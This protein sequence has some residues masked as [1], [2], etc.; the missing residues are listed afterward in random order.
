LEREL[1]SSYYGRRDAQW[2][3]KSAI[4]S[5]RHLIYIETPGFCSTSALPPSKYAADLIAT[6]KTQLQDRPGLRAIICVPKVPDFAPGYEGMSAYEVQ[7]RLA[8][9]RGSTTANP[10]VAPMPDAQSIVFHPVGFPGRFSRV[11]T[12]VVIVDDIWVMIGGAS[13]R[14]RGLT[15]D[16]SSDLVVTDTLIENGRSAAIRDFR[17][18]LM[19]NRLGL[20]KADSTQPS[21]VALSEASTAFLLVK[22]AVDL[23]DIKPLWDGVTPGVTPMPPLPDTQANPDGRDLDILTAGFIAVFGNVSGV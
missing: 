4:K 20:D 23:G 12:N 18:G 13:L 8:I 16:G 21:Y 7:D 6:L 3:L 9:V 14:R 22:N 11:E 1:T 19:A 5:A 10:V 15:M 2:A 17:R